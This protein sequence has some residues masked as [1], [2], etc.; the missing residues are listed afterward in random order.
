MRLKIYGYNDQGLSAE[1]IK[2]LELVEITLVANPSELRRIVAFLTSAADRMEN[3]GSKYGHEHLS[4][5]QPGFD[6]SPHFV[7]FSPA[8]Q[9]AL[10]DRSVS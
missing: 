10:I 4:D 2:P 9:A 5:K 3:L 6:A 7:V 1:E 8:A